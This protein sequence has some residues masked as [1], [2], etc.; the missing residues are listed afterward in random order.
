MIDR[1][2]FTSYYSLSCLFHFLCFCCPNFHLAVIFLFVFFLV[3]SIYNSNKSMLK[4]TGLIKHHVQW[5]GLDFMKK[6]STEFIVFREKEKVKI[7]ILIGRLYIQDKAIYGHMGHIHPIYVH[8][9][10]AH[11]LYIQA[12]RR[13]VFPLFWTQETYST[14]KNITYTYSNQNSVCSPHRIKMPI[15]C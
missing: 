3:F 14:Y 4:F 6:R 9:L 12:Y 8:I 11:I 7:I 13:Q 5:R 10:Y 1:H 15:A 2:R